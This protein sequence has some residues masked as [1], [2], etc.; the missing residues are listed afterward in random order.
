[1]RSLP[2]LK[3]PYEHPAAKSAWRGYFETR[4]PSVSR[5]IRPTQLEPLPIVKIEDDRRLPNEHIIY[6][7]V[8]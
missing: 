3:G 7:L 8:V 4:M 6:A 5:S 1:M 2:V